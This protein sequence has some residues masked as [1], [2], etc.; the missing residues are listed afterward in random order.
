M[1]H[2]GA[3]SMDFFEIVQICP[4]ILMLLTLIFVEEPL[5]FEYKTGRRPNFWKK[6]RLRNWYSFFIWNMGAEEKKQYYLPLTDITWQNSGR[7]CQWMKEPTLIHLNQST[8]DE[9][10]RIV[11]MEKNW[12]DKVLGNKLR[13][14][15]LE[16]ALCCLFEQRNNETVAFN[17]GA[18]G[19]K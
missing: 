15:T 5:T 4:Q 1:R 19:K 8:Y 3:H 14:T 16:Y 9:L 17:P 11:Y 7:A 2:C 10:Q 18:L 12:V 6:T 13:P